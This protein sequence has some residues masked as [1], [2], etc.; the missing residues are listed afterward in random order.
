MPI[1]MFFSTFLADS[2]FLTIFAP[3]NNKRINDEKICSPAFRRLPHGMEWRTGTGEGGKRDSGSGKDLVRTN[4]GK[5]GTEPEFEECE[6]V[7]DSFE[8]FMEKVMSGGIQL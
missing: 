8:D 7:A 5:D 2:G 4:H 6:T 1:F 3:L